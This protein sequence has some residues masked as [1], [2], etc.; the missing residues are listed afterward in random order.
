MQTTKEDFGFWDKVFNNEIEYSRF[1]V[2]SLALVAVGC[3]GGM[4]VGLG[5]IDSVVQLAL[6]VFPTMAALSF[7]LAVMPMKWI[8]NLSIFAVTIDLII[9]VFNLLT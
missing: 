3:L 7:C 4:A 9:I 1:S 5:A 8:L 2:I 6:V